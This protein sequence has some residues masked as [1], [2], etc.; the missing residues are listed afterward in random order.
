[1]DIVRHELTV[2][3]SSWA[4]SRMGGHAEL[5]HGLAHV[6]VVLGLVLEREPLS[7][8]YR[9]LR[10]EDPALRGTA[11]EYLDVVLPPDLRDL[12]MPLLGDVKAPA[13][14]RERGRRELADELLKSQA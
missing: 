12:V 10:A 2:G 5:R 6:F 13:R 9:A 4:A 3:R 1:M 11:I 7:I 8:A 14:R